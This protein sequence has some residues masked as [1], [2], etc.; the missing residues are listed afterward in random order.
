M[1]HKNHFTMEELEFLALVQGQGESAV[2][3]QPATSV[4]TYHPP[5][6]RRDIRRD[7]YS[8]VYQAERAVSRLEIAY[9]L[10]LKKTPW[11]IAH[12]EQL[13]TEGYLIRPQERLACGMTMYWYAVAS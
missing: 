6:V 9:L 13:L 3:S 5:P 10:G 8:A 7:I 1:Q 4:G 11:L 2:T 12:I